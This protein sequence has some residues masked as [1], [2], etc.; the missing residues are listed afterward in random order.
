VAWG[1]A[2]LALAPIALHY[3]LPFT[4]RPVDV[5]SWFTTVGPRVPVT[6]VVVTYPFASSGL[7]APMTWQAV[8]SLRFSLVGGGSITP[9]PPAHPTV[10]EVAVTRAG[11]DLS[12]LSDGFS[13]LPTG[14]PVEA[15]RLRL[16]LHSWGA[17]TVVVPS[18]AT[19]PTALR[20]RSVPVAVAMF[21]TALGS[22]PRWQSDAWVWDVRRNPGA[23]LV[24]P[25]AAFV[26]CTTSSAAA[27]DPGR[28]AACVLA[29]AGA[30]RTAAP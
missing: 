10:V 24:V 16:A 14:R 3:R 19:W 28:A 25:E 5:P 26:G 12:N 17:T 18:E 20:G 2:A 11:V 1:L 13:P 9:T 21:T 6:D 27:I 30:T 8:G 7:R 29:A 23:P 22:G 4:T 15:A